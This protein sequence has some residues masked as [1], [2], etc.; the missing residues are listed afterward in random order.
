MELNPGQVWRHYKGNHYKIICLGKHSE[1]GEE[2][3]AYMRQEDG[4]IYF[5]PLKIFFSEVEWEG[6]K[7]PR[8]VL[9]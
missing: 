9:C 1:T 3:V 8:F 2:L 5:R 7:M 4:K 6:K